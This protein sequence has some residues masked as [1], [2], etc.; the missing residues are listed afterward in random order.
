M[1]THADNLSE[2]GGDVFAQAPMPAMTTGSNQSGTQTGAGPQP[3]RREGGGN[4]PQGWGK[5][6]IPVDT[7][8][9]RYDVTRGRGTKPLT[10]SASKVDRMSANEAGDTL[11]AIHVMFGIDREVEARLV[12][13]DNA[14]FFEHS[15]NGASLLQPGRGELVVDGMVFDIHPFKEKLGVDQRRFFR[16]FA[17]DIA[18]VNKQVLDSYDPYDPVSVEKV[19][20]IK[21]IAAV[22]GLQKY[23][24][25]IHDSSDACSRLSYDERA[26]VANSKR[27]VL[28]SVVNNA[29]ALLA[30]RVGS[31]SSSR[32][33]GGS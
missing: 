32:G 18:D 23:P 3:L 5:G 30:P 16:A 25:L 17:D 19:G 8:K 20:F 24:H 13:F 21:Q 31:G 22:R 26:A 6:P 10:F 9:F 28:D 15:I 1:A 7:R 11:E 27:V 4:T 12:A 33:I 29:D 14:L 2:Y